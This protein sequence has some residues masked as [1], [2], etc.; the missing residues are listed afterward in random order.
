MTVRS[1]SVRVPATTANLGPGFDCL[2]LALDLWNEADL[3]LEGTGFSVSVEGEGAALPA[4][5]RRQPDRGA[6]FRQYYSSNGLPEPD[7]VHPSTAATI[8]RA[9]RGLAPAHRPLCLDCWGLPCSTKMLKATRL[10]GSGPRPDPLVQAEVLHLAAQMEGHPDNAAAARLWRAGRRDRPGN[11][12][13]GAQVRPATPFYGDHSPRE[14]IF[15]PTR[16]AR[17]LPAAIPI[18]DAVYN[19]GR[20]VLVVEALRNGDLDL[21]GKVMDDRLHQPYPPGP[22]PRRRGGHAVGL[23]IQGSR[24]GAFPAPAPA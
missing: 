2:G 23:S 11:R 17:P 15:R 20:T 9:A 24:C 10:P 14:S 18:K 5:R 19:L 6:L 21:L 12:H 3:S 1:I 22:D 13:A 7:G 4:Q 16:R 8:S